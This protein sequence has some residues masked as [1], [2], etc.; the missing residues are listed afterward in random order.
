M[1]H[2]SSGLY[3]EDEEPSGTDHHTRTWCYNLEDHNSGYLL[4]ASHSFGLTNLK[5]CATVSLQL[6]C[7][8]VSIMGLIFFCLHVSNHH[9]KLLSVLLQW[10]RCV[11][12]I[13]WY[14][15]FPKYVEYCGYPSARCYSCQ[16][17]KQLT[18]QTSGFDSDKYLE[19]GLWIIMWCMEVITTILE[20]HT[21]PPHTHTHTPSQKIII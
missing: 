1:L 4:A 12:F 5:V 17:G 16:E 3:H 10:R 18:Y 2:V 9:G 13:C 15:K 14:P 19:Y 21:P 11:A 7:H 6:L 8:C 20:E